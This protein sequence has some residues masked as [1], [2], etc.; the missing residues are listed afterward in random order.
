MNSHFTMSPEHA[1][2]LFASVADSLR[3]A[4]NVMLHCRVSEDSVLPDRRCLKPAVLIA[5]DENGRDKRVLCDC[6]QVRVWLFC[7]RSQSLCVLVVLQTVLLTAITGWD[8]T[9]KQR[10]PLRLWSL[11]VLAALRRV[12]NAVQSRSQTD[13]SQTVRRLRPLAR[14]R[15]RTARPF[16]V[17]MRARKPWVRFC[18]MVLGWKVRFM[19]CDPIC[20]SP[21]G[22]KGARY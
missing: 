14:R 15:A 3:R 13:K 4:M 10:Y 18:L 21:T 17:A 11:P 9:W 6:D 16:L 2:V 7:E 5:N 1:S 19:I 20:S 8:L 12:E 22:R